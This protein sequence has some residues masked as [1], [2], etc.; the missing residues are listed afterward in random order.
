MSESLR[1]DSRQA[2]LC[3][4]LKHRDDDSDHARRSG[5]KTVGSG[6]EKPRLRL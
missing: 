6:R 5:M 3:A 4:V 1:A 2:D